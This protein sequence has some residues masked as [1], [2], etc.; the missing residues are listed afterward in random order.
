LRIHNSIGDSPRFIGIN[1]AGK[2]R[3]NFTCCSWYFTS[4]YFSSILSGIGFSLFSPF[5]RHSIKNALKNTFK[6]F[7]NGLLTL[8]YDTS[9]ILQ[10]LRSETEK[11]EYLLRNNNNSRDN[12]MG[13]GGETPP[14]VQYVNDQFSK[15]LNDKKINGLLRSDKLTLDY[16]IKPGDIK[17]YHEDNDLLF[18]GA[19]IKYLTPS[20]SY[21]EFIKSLYG[22]GDKEA[23]KK[24]CNA[25]INTEYVNKL[26]CSKTGKNVYI[27]E[28]VNIGRYNPISHQNSSKSSSSR[29][30]SNICKFGELY[31]ID[32]LI[33]FELTFPKEVSLLA[34]KNPEKYK[35]LVSD[36]SKE[37]IEDYLKPKY[38]RS[39]NEMLGIFFN[40]HLWSSKNPLNSHLHAHFNMLNCVVIKEE[41][42]IIDNLSEKSKKIVRHRAI[43]FKPNLTTDELKEMRKSWKNILKKHDIEIDSNV[44]IYWK[45]ISLKNKAQ[46]MHRIKYCTRKPIIDIYNY[47]EDALYNE[48]INEYNKKYLKY[49]MEYNNKRHVFGFMK[50]LKRLIP[51]ENIEHY[52]PICG[53]KAEKC[54]VE[55]KELIEKLKNREA[56]FLLFD[57]KSKKYWKVG[58]G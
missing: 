45:Y 40:P 36:L 28:Y 12:I 25:D 35:A 21:I 11:K 20:D 18:L 6:S 3:N 4:L 39:K 33:T 46:V 30:A 34:V 57:W 47:Y 48:D 15:P 37:F 50:F 5:L 53:E 32:Y 29:L 1:G 7:L 56:Y 9:G 26:K 44:N 31:K 51:E 10:P 27:P 41:K 16:D 49:L 17:L 52:C 55:V 23:V 58:I 24:L 13:G 54:R 42:E 22:F 14:Y 8:L 2:G 43:R 19:F 38:L